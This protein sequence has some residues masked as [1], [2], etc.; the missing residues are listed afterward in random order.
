MA[1][2]FH[3]RYTYGVA[4]RGWVGK[5]VRVTGTLASTRSNSGHVNGRQQ[6]YSWTRIGH[7]NIGGKVAVNS[8]VSSGD[9]LRAADLRVQVCA[10]HW[11][12]DHCVERLYRE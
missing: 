8:D 9:T 4:R 1:Q 3:G 12:G 6:G 10:E 7:V 2:S 5:A 11:Y